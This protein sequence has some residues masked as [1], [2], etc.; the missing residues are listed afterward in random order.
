MRKS[1]ID[2]LTNKVDDFD[3][4]IFSNEELLQSFWSYGR[5]YEEE[6]INFIKENYKKG[7]TYIDVGACIGNHTM[8]FS[9]LADKVYSFEP[10]SKQFFHMQLNLKIN[11][12]T[13]VI[14][15]N[16][17]LGNENKF[18]KMTIDDLSV[19]GTTI[20]KD[21]EHFGA[22]LKL[23]DMK[24]NDVKLIKIDV[25]EYEKE[26]L[27]GAIDTIKR[28]APDIYIECSTELEMVDNFN[29]V[30]SINENYKIFPSVF[31]NTPTYLFTVNPI[32]DYNIIQK[33]KSK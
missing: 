13:N 1:S 12:L 27:I 9:T 15:L 14:P 29:I 20:Q 8:F 33:V 7:G 28:N 21:G 24:L 19:G 22:V 31:N 32:E 10:N 2:V 18:V 17:G 30:K 11:D 3:L 4:V 16:I 6:M 5:W 23:D 25:Q 26:V